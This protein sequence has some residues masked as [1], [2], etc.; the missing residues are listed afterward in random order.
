MSRNARLSLVLH[1]DDFGMSRAI[2]DGIIKG[3][4][5]GVLTSTSL[6]ANGP[7]VHRAAGE[8]RRLESDRQ[9]GSLPSLQKRRPLADANAPF[10]LGVHL[11]LTQGVPLRSDYPD[12]LRDD[13]GRF[14]GIGVL[15]A[16]VLLSPARYV[17][18]IRAEL[19]DQISRVRDLGC[20]PTH[21]NGHQ[22]IEMLA[23]VRQA[24]NPLLPLFGIDIVRRPREPGVLFGRS[25]VRGPISWMIAF[26]KQSF[27]STMQRDLEARRFRFTESYFGTMLAGRVTLTHV[28]RFIHRSRPTSV[29][30]I[31]L[32]P[33]LSVAGPARWDDPW[34]DPLH[35]GRPTELAW[36][37]SDHVVDLLVKHGCHLT[38]LSSL[39]AEGVAA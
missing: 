18:F 28:E 12:E 26:L 30:E 24:L 34:F 36:L 13:G 20:R 27:S 14:V 35:A 38:R 17:P 3:F 5:D 4:R 9:I 15:T 8:W 32:H 16:R 29:I 10:D 23:P 21:V 33:A 31:G 6:L 2:S 25:G 37:V 11:N 39:S 1:A 22:Y 7:D 19:R